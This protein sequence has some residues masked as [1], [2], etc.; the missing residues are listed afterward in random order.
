[1]KFSQRHGINPI[2]KPLQ[3]ESID[4][5]LRIGLWNIYKI[6]VLDVINRR[7]AGNNSRRREFFI[8]IYL[9]HFKMDID[10]VPYDFS[11][12]YN[13]IKKVFLY[14]AQWYEV[15]ELIE[16]SINSIKMDSHHFFIDI[17]EFQDFINH[18]LEKEFSGYRIINEIFVPIS[19]ES[20]VKEIEQAIQISKQFTMLL[21]SNVHLTEALRIISDRKTTDY[22]NSIKESISAIET[23]ARV[24]SEKKT[25]SLGKALSK[26]KAKVGLHS[27]LEEG[28]K[29]I[30]GYTSDEG[31]IR[32]SLMDESNC[33]FDDAKYMLV[34]S[35][36]FINYLIAKA[37]KAGITFT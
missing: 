9:N 29:K 4:N 37:I 22:R 1:M 21:G 34:S 16:A 7:L 28:F 23:I 26:V 2:E 11:A 25:D 15:F 13:I 31:G 14:E 35:S 10:N 19:N 12:A 24:I 17:L 3:I 30:Y 27:S 18:T 33:D 6:Y 32:H 36:A 20:E 5:D 8:R